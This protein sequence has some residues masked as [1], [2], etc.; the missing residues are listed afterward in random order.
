MN[1]DYI[2]KSQTA[3][4]V[5]LDTKIDLSSAASLKIKYKKPSGATGSWTATQDSTYPTRIYFDL[6]TASID[7]SGVWTF[8]SY[9]TFNDGRV[10]PGKACQKYIQVEGT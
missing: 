3:L 10:A 2:F 4:K 9:V 1:E 5:R 7:E 8:W 6:V